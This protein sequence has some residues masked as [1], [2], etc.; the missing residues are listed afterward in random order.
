MN[1][2]TCGMHI[3]DRYAE[4][5]MFENSR[6]GWSGGTS[7]C[8]DC[9]HVETWIAH[10]LYSD[11]TDGSTYQQWGGPPARDK[12][13]K[14]ESTAPLDPNRLDPTRLPI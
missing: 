13:H 1:C 5:R 10:C 14:Q 3:A 9:G 12:L 11:G 4:I 6:I 2:K 8:P 7:I